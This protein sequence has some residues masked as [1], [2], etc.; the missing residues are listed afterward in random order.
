MDSYHQV[1][2]W[3][4]AHCLEHPVMVETT[5]K[6]VS[7]ASTLKPYVDL[8][9]ELTDV[10][11]PEEFTDAVEQAARAEITGEM[12]AFTPD[13]VLE[14][15][16][17]IGAATL[18]QFEL[19][20]AA[21]DTSID[22]LQNPEIGGR[23]VEAEIA[24][25]MKLQAEHDISQAELAND[26]EKYR[27]NIVEQYAGTEEM[28]QQLDRFDQAAMEEQQQ[29]A[30]Q[31]A[32]E[33]QRLQDEQQLQ[34]LQREQEQLEQGQLQQE[35]VQEEQRQEELRLEEEAKQ[36]ERQQEEQRHQEELH[37]EQLQ[38][39]QIRQEQIRQ[40][41]IRLEQIRLEQIRLEQIRLEEIRRAAAARAAMER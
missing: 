10:V 39:E 19:G 37:Q 27:Q 33:M 17:E 20:E 31:Q 11:F 34:Q 25:I 6:M 41:Q 4:T 13:E 29:L 3:F 1:A 8:A 24:E 2:A 16:A 35:Q 9:C 15:I 30:D 40:E 22:E 14:E 12:E 38:Q 18:E 7:W 36:E 26:I 5:I 23:Q 28:Q 32:T 21:E